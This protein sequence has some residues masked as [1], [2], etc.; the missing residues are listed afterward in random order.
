MRV[1]LLVRARVVLAVVRHPLGHRPLDRHRPEDRERGADD[2]GRLEAAMREQAVVAHG[3]AEAG[4]DVE[5]EKEDDV[6]P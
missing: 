3:R 2:L 5:H 4:E 6:D 1:T